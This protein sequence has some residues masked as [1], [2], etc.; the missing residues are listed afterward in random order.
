MG[1]V[2][3]FLSFF[4]S[5]PLRANGKR[6]KLDLIETL[7]RNHGELSRLAEQIFTHAQKAPY[8]AVAQKLEQL[9]HEKKESAHRLREK[10]LGLGAKVEEALGE[11]R[12]GKNHWARIAQDLGDQRELQ[13]RLVADASRLA[14]ENPEISDLL[15]HIEAREVAHREV[16][17]DLLARADPQANLT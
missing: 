12:S 10:I 3:R 15:R 4:N 7:T 17:M 6:E 9:S 11:L 8:P 16:L 13:E 2:A 14:I 5:F 1:F